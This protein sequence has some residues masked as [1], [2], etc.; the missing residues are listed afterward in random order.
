MLALYSYFAATRMF[1]ILFV[2][3]FKAIHFSTTVLLVGFCFKSA[4]VFSKLIFKENFVAIKSSN[5]YIQSQKND[6]T[7]RIESVYSFL[8]AGVEEKMIWEEK[9]WK[10]FEI[11]GQV[12]D[13]K[14]KL[15]KG[16]GKLFNIGQNIEILRFEIPTGFCFDQ[17]L[18][19]RGLNKL[20]KIE[21]SS[22][23]REF[24]IMR[25][26]C[27]YSKLSGENVG[28]V[29]FNFYNQKK[30]PKI[31]KNRNFKNYRNLKYWI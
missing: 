24:D 27:I 1:D 13:S 4:I 20:F 15:L 10:D 28:N 5:Q 9:M 22:R 16:L 23:Y 18:N 21:E 29:K 30:Q 2:R 7:I 3:Y 8:L 11:L 17:L 14:R 12:R 26:N 19:T 31:K 6:K 25:V